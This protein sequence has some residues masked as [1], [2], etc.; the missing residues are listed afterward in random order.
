MDWIN[1]YELIQELKSSNDMSIKVH[2]RIYEYLC[3]TYIL[4]YDSSTNIIVVETDAAISFIS[5][6]EFIK[7]Y[8]NNF[9]KLV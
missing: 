4:K 9:W 5:E 2:H 6:K 8:V 3:N 7:L 1:T